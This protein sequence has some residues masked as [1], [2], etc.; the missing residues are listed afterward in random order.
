MALELGPLTA[1]VIEAAAGLASQRC[2]VQREATPQL[3]ASI[4]RPATWRPYLQR[5]I[6]R[7][8]IWPTRSMRRLL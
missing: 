6:E 3:P 5:I 2:Q 1:E 8:A 4:G 7:G